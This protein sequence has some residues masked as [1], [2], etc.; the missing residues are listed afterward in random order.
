L[1]YLNNQNADLDVFGTLKIVGASGTP[2]SIN[3]TYAP[4]NTRRI[5]IDVT[6]AAADIEANEYSISYLVNEGLYVDASASVGAL[7]PNNNF[8]NGS[9]S[10]MRTDG[11][12]ARCYIEIDADDP[13]TTID[14]VI[15]NYSGTPVTG[16]HFNVKRN[17]V[18]ADAITFDNVSGLIGTVTYEDDGGTVGNIGTGG[19]TTP[20]KIIWPA[21]TTKTWE[22]NIDE[23]WF[24]DANWNPA[25]A[26]LATDNV[27]IPSTAAT[28]GNN[29]EISGQ[30]GA[31]CNDLTITDGVLSVDDSRKLEVEGDA[32]IGTGS[33]T[34]ICVMTGS[35]CEIEVAGSWFVG[36]NGIFTHGNGLVTFDAASGSV[37]IQSQDDDFGD[38]E[39][40]GDATF[41][42]QTTDVDVDGD[43]TMTRGNVVHNT[44]DYN[45][46]V[47]GDY[48]RNTSNAT[49]DATTIGK[50]IFNGGIQAIANGQFNRLEISGAGN[51]TASGTNTVIYDNTGEPNKA[52]TVNSGAKLTIA[53]G[54]TLDIEGNVL[55]ASGGELDDGGNDI[56][57]A[58][59]Y[60]TGTGTYSDNSG[61]VTFDADGTPQ[62]IDASTFNTL[63]LNPDNRQVYLRGDIDIRDDLTVEDGINQLYCYGYLIDNIESDGTFTMDENE[64]INITG[65]NNFPDNFQ[66]YDLDSTSYT[67]YEGTGP[68]T[69]RGGVTYG[70]L[71]LYEATT[72]TLGGNIGVGSYL[73]FNTATLDVS[74]NNYTISIAGHWY[75]QSTGSFICRNGTVI[76]DLDIAYQ[77]IRNTTTGSSNFYNITVNKSS[78]QARVYDNDITVLNNLRVIN[79]VFNASGYTVTVGGNMT[80]SGGGT[81]Y[82]S[83]TYVMTT[84]GSADLQANGSILFNYTLNGTGTVTLQDDLVVNGDFYIAKGTF[85]GNGNTA[86]LGNGEDAITIGD[87]SASP[88]IYKIGAGGTLKMGN[89]DNFT[90]STNGTIYVVG[91]AADPATVTHRTSGNRYYFNVHGTIHAKYYK[92]ES[93]QDDGIYIC[94]DGTIDNTDNFSYGSFE[95]II[96]GGIALRVENT[97]SFTDPSH[98]ADVSFPVNPGGGAYNVVKSV[99]TSGTLEFYNAQGNFSGESF[100]NDP[101][102]KIDWTGPVVLTWT[103]TSVVDNTDWFDATNWSP[104]SGPQI[105]PNATTDAVIANTLNQPIIDENPGPNAITKKLTINAGAHLKITTAD[106]L[107]EDLTVSGDLTIYGQLT[108]TGSN[109]DIYVA[110]NWL[111]SGGIVTPN[112]GTVYLNPSSGTKNFNNGT[113]ALYNIVINTAGTVQLGSNTNVSNNLTITTGTLDVSSSNR[114]LTVGGNFINAGIFNAQSGKVILNSTDA[115]TFTPAGSHFNNIDV[116]GNGNPNYTLGSTLYVDGYFDMNSGAFD[117]AGNTFNFGNGSGSDN[118]TIDGGTFYIDANASLKM[119]ASSTISVAN[120]ATISIVG[121]DADNLAT[122]T[123]QS[124]G[125]YSFTVGGTIMA[126]YYLMERMDASGVKLLSTATIDPADNF[127]H[128]TFSL[129]AT[130]GKYLRLEN[131]FG[132]F[133]ATDVY[134]N[135]G[136]SYNVSRPNTATGVITFSDAFGAMA[137]EVYDD[138]DGNLVDWEYSVTTIFWDGNSDADGDGSDWGDIFNWDL[139]RL[140]NNGDVVIIPNIGGSPVISAA[141][142]ETGKLTVQ[143]GATLTVNGGFDLL[144]ETGELNNAGT[145][146]VGNSATAIEVAGNFVNTGTY[147]HGNSTLVLKATSGIKSITTGGASIYD[148]TINDAGGT[149]IYESQGNIT[150]S[151]DLTITNGTF[152]ISDPGHN[153]YIKGDFR[154]DDTFQ[155]GNGTVTFNGT[156]DQD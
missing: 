25:A 117:L 135:S 33:S 83:G 82:T 94:S 148:L 85:N 133:T 21:I 19:E 43:F 96:A 72:K 100:D 112:T 60:W 46:Y 37:S 121:A 39:F 99:A 35:G 125:S 147:N 15:F 29:P 58:G 142:R 132:D 9:W 63:V 151:N 11:T 17:A 42:F 81:F 50:F 4:A 116:N 28:T 68:Q 103:G 8:S 48:D 122:V 136:P 101:S 49:F 91:D 13:G 47:G 65:A 26:P 119:G 113:S 16:R 52:L 90:V 70:R 61:T 57:F 5:D 104:S 84:G 71:R 77:Y 31:V 89:E 3:G 51:K 138:D 106:L 54:G 140:P 155:H 10:N 130:G 145:I 128:G 95:N 45:I 123:R 36:S 59:R 40:D 7:D 134:F 87:G 144:V 102:N 98:I 78:G 107:S 79:G 27:I 62:Y 38:I 139:E 75:N 111:R 6:G 152:R 120:G 20:G 22:G 24:T 86:S 73:Q 88:A 66:T 124:S 118:L 109:D 67:D 2:A 108:L 131:N 154:N 149:V 34:G 127:S 129:G 14:N 143:S 53:P 56:T 146:T 110:G 80:A 141:N 153:L 156:G 32:Y 150:V 64:I 74:A 97:Q 44:D 23:D 69:I 30:D 41:A 1:F 76:F 18:A 92:F 93:M 114:T 126:R 137:G 115:A 105:I 12:A 55:I